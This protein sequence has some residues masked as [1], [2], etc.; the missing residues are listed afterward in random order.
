MGGAL[1]G[2]RLPWG[3]C[4]G[5]V[6]SECRTRRVPNEVVINALFSG[7]ACQL[8]VERLWVGSE[9]KVLQ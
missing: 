4:I 5:D 1:T 6:S 3:R 8:Q 7:S 9:A 2:K